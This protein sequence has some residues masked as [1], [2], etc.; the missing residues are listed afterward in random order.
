MAPGPA[1]GPRTK[2]EEPRTLLSLRATGEPMRVA[3]RFLISGRVQGVGFRFFAE[4]AGRR[5]GLQGAVRNLPDGSVE[6]VC[7]GPGDAM[8]RF[9]LAIRQGPPGA[10]VDEVTVQTIPIGLHEQGFRRHD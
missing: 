10:R 9:E 5:E 3:R 2:A 7:E 8:A 1:D 6:A 4:A